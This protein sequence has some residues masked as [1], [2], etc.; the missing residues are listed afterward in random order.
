MSRT[1]QFFAVVQIIYFLDCI[2]ER[3]GRFLQ[4]G[5]INNLVVVN[6][7]HKH[8]N[9]RLTTYLAFSGW[10][11]QEANRLHSCTE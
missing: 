9:S 1:T 4:F 8:K 2:Y 3:C 5:A 10:K 7:I 6:T 11:H